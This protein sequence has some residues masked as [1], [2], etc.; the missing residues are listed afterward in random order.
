[1]LGFSSTTT[2]SPSKI[3]VSVRIALQRL[4]LRA[5]AT[6][7]DADLGK[8]LFHEDAADALGRIAVDDRPRKR[9]SARWSRG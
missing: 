1:M 7:G 3:S 9:S 6:Q 2:R 8:R 4:E 5:R